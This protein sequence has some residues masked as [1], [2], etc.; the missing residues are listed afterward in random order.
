MLEASIDFNGVRYSK[1]ALGYYGK[2]DSSNKHPSILVL[3]HLY[4]ARISWVFWGR[5]IACQAHCLSL[6][7]VICIPKLPS[8][9]VIML[10]HA[11]LILMV[12]VFATVSFASVLL[13]Y[14]PFYVG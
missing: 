14:F 3:A 7:P 9:T 2:F 11:S 1:Q 4:S 13:L 5:Y 8:P 12:K 6:S 10:L